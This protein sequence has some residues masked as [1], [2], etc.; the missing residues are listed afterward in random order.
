MISKIKP[1]LGATLIMLIMGFGIYQ[2]NP[3]HD[4]L[5]AIIDFC[6]IIG[7]IIGSMVAF[8]IVIFFLLWCF[9]GD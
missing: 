6:K 5:E 9:N 2:A 4:F 1:W 8:F 3:K 7:I